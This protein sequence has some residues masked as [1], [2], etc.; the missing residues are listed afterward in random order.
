MKTID[1]YYST[2]SIYAYLGA[3]RIVDLAR[4][5]GRRLVHRP[6]DLSRVVPAAGSQPFDKRS[7]AHKA[8]QFG[9]EIERWSEY[10]GIPALVDPVHHFG[11]RALSAG[12]I[13]AAQSAGADVDRLHVDML[14]ALWRDDRDLS[15]AEVLAS[16]VSGVGADATAILDAARSEDVQAAFNQCS[17][18]AI[19]AGV[20]GSPTYVV[21]GDLFYGQDR[22]MMVE[23]ALERPFA[24]PGPP[25]RW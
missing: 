4:R 24:P 14:T 21:D 1:Y 19:A 15:S 12:V 25:P 17:E 5:F 18:R 16:L 3:Q 10:L 20:P 9:R 23:R 2:R 11:D 6:V 8:Y 7:A 13:L 22:L